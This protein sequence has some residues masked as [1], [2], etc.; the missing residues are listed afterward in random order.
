MGFVFWFLVIVMHVCAFSQVAFEEAAGRM[1]DAY[2][3]AG[4]EKRIALICSC[5]SSR[6]AVVV[7][8]GA[9]VGVV[10]VLMVLFIL[11]LLLLLLLMVLCCCSCA[12]YGV[13][14]LCYCCH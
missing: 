7:A 2:A 6:V 12:C 5:C 3:N 9:P 13:V 10:V 14:S 11:L 8:I 4:E 1:A